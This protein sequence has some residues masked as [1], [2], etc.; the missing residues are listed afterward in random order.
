MM[1]QTVVPQGLAVQQVICF[2]MDRFCCEIN[3]FRLKKTI[4]LDLICDFDS[5]YF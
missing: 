3:E 5:M 1:Q 4:F 2:K